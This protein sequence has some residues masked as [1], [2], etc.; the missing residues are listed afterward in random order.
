MEEIPIRT[1]EELPP[2]VPP[3]ELTEPARQLILKAGSDAAYG[4]RPLKRTIQKEV[5]T[6]LGRMLLE[7]K[8]RDGQ[9]IRGEYKE[10]KGLTFAPEGVL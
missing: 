1:L 10:G 8:I 9:T 7:G 2:E 6:V 5:E 3:F 4:A